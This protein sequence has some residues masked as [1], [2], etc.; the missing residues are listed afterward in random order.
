MADGIKNVDTLRER[1]WSRFKA[2]QSE[3]Q[4]LEPDYR[5]LRE[6]F[7]P[8]R[9]R[10]DRDGNSG[11]AGNRQ[12]RRAR[13]PNS[14]PVLATRTAGSGLHA[15][16]TAPSRP[17]FKFGLYDDSLA[18]FGP[19]KVWLADAEDALRK[20]FNVSNLYEML[21]FMFS[22]YA[23]MGTMCGLC[24]EDDR[25]PRAPMR[26]EWYTAG[27]YWLG[28]DY[29][30]GY[31][32]L[33]REMT[34][35]T[36]QVVDRFGKENVRGQILRDWNACNYD[37]PVRILH[38]IEPEKGGRGSTS[39]YWTM[40]RDPGWDGLLADRVFAENPILAAP[41][42]RVYGETY[43][44]NCPGMIALGDARALQIDEID[45]ARALQR[46]HNPPLQG[47]ALLA[48]AGISLAPG[49]YN[50]IPGY[51]ATAGNGIRSLY[52]FKPDITGLLDNIQRNERRIN[53]AFF[54]DL[55]LMLT[56]DERAQRST[57]E[58]IRAKYDE[59]V[60]ALGPTLE[61]ANNMLRGLIDR[62]FGIMV[63]R[64]QPIWE[65]RMDG[66]PLLP[67]PPEDLQDEEIQIEFVSTLQQAMRAS[68]L[69]GIERFATFALQMAQA[70]GQPP[71]KL[72][73]EQAMDEYGAALGVPP[74]IVRSDEDV[75]AM[76]EQAA[77]AQQVQQMAAVAPALRDAAGAA[78]DLAEAK[79]DGT[80]ALSAITG[81]MAG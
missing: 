66:E 69:Q 27:Q 36:R 64:S 28:T 5:E 33:L 42:E 24:L 3:R 13:L 60:L 16:L 77:K 25:K 4:Q 32:T 59:K 76:R 9:G 72:D 12:P 7:L 31:D 54:T 23:A 20:A 79:P 14:T 57:A 29:A 35:T 74:R 58:E 37:K 73:A 55:F 15:G 44:T 63:R 22:E 53:Q 1:T 49:T 70:T 75:A 45:K 38:A 18:E 17:W 61:Q 71:A 46:H 50:E 2:M 78:K 21:P 47:P 62:A 43:G 10:F 34:L 56:Q 26:F 65:G 40:A 41:W 68:T 8:T 52:D 30:G 81:G 11:Q 67:P 6:N 48:R 80:D 51:G 19:V 39:R